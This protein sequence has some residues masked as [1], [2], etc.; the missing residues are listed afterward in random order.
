M[1]KLK[2]DGRAKIMCNLYEA[3]DVWRRFSEEELVRY[4]CFRV[5]P[6]GRY[7]VQ[8]ADHYHL[9]LAENLGR[10]DEEQFI[11]LLAKEAPDARGKTYDTIE[12]AID[13]FE[14]DFDENFSGLN[15]LFT[16]DREM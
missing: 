14:K 8:S 4:R 12:E 11:K 1:T 9:P 6:E 5:L 7:C 13:M 2:Q 15:G 10:Q 16:I 3:V